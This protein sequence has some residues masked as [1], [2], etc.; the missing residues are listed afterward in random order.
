M[1][2]SLLTL[3][4]RQ[5]RPTSSRTTRHG[6]A[7]G[8][9]IPSLRRSFGSVDMAGFTETPLGKN[10]QHLLEG[11]E[12]HSISSMADSHPLAVYSLEGEHSADRK[13]ILLLHGRTWSAVPV[14]H[15]LGGHQTESRSLMESLL[16]RGL[17]PYAMDFRGFGGTPSDATGY[18]EP[19]RCVSDTE[20]VLEW[21]RQRHSS[22]AQDEDSLPSLLGWSQGAMVAQLVAQ[23]QDPLVSR[24][25][26]Y[27]SI[28][29][30][31]IRYP[32]EPLYR[33]RNP[34]QTII[35]N[36][37]DDAVEDF[38]LEGTIPP[39][40]AKKFAEA[41]LISDPIKA[42][43]KHLY[44]FNN[45]NPARI[46]APTLVIAGDQDPYA[47]I[48]VQ[49]HIFNNLPPTFDRTFSILANADHAVHLLEG[50]ARLINSIANFVLSEKSSF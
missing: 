7:R 25:I 50:R 14:Y 17:Q 33:I 10:G 47:P 42:V 19:H 3:F 32:R 23:K 8:K 39:E 20:T 6:A 43:W 35:E 13:P 21:I 18:V 2:R 36:H 16:Q 41:A 44:Q 40:P 48:H 29:D 5:N 12:V 11:L 27:G 28:Y 4:L 49:S 38:T 31:Q 1:A 45:C 46:H 15:L 24:L 37:F 9:D 34:N 26:L 22:Q 30:P